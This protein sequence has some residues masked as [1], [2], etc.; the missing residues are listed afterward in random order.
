MKS[1]WLIFC[2]CFSIAFVSCIKERVDECPDQYSI[3]LSVKDKNYFNVAASPL[4]RSKDENLAFRQY[5]NN[6]R[7]T[8]L[9]LDNDLLYYDSQVFSVSNDDE[10]QTL[11]FN[12]VPSGRYLLTVWGNLP[13]N[14][15]KSSF[16]LHP[17]QTESSDVYVAF[18]ELQFND[19]LQSKTLNLE[20]AKGLLQIVYRDFPDTIKKIDIDVS[21]LFQS[22]T[23]E[24]VY[25]GE[26]G[27]TKSFVLSNA[28]NVMETFLAPTA[29]GKISGLNV[30]LY[31]ANNLPLF[32]STTL[33]MTMRRNEIT[34]IE[35]NYNSLDR[36]FAFWMWIDDKWA[37]IYDLSIVNN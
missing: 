4:A 17:L 1:K 26:T 6:L 8:L 25:S 34:I 35:I 2:L 24:L 18:T 30:T 10:T 23:N 36:A 19:R 31:N 12:N 21:S 11:H 7:Y 37:K 14:S 29:D 32:T 28:T 16:D 13:D 20:R 5:V 9:D 27:V 3:H 22:T 33:D 15:M